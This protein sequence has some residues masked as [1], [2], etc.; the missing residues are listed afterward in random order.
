[1][2][3][4][5]ENSP[6][7]NPLFRSNGGCLSPSAPPSSNAENNANS[8]IF[9]DPFEIYGPVTSEF[10]YPA[11]VAYNQNDE[12][13]INSGMITELAILDSARVNNKISNSNVTDGNNIVKRDRL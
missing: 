11:E 7:I 5:E 6:L 2:L 10:V 4:K 3:K 8:I 1:M 13:W 9:I 12:Y